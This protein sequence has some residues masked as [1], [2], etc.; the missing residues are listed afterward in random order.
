M[1]SNIKTG[2]ITVKVKMM[3]RLQSNNLTTTTIHELLD[4]SHIAKSLR[5]QILTY[6]RV[7]DAGIIKCFFY[8]ADIV[9][10]VTS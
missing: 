6:G 2:V 4:P 3:N 1:S 9:S 10:L 7:A 5:T 8:H